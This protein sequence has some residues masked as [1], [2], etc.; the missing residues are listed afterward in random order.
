MKWDS[1]EAADLEHDRAERKRKAK[2]PSPEASKL[3]KKKVD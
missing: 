2:G 3:L 1:L